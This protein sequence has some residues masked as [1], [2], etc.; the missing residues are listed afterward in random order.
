MMNRTR[1]NTLMDQLRPIAQQ[2]AQ[3]MR[4][5]AAEVAEQSNPNSGL[6][7]A[8]IER[9]ERQAVKWSEITVEGPK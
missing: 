5:V 7:A 8:Y 2:N 6:A 1:F 9:I 3:F 4:Q